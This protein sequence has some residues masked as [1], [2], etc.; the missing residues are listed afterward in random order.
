V[1][2]VG[3][4]GAGKSTFARTHFRPTE[5]VSSDAC[6]ALVADDENDQ[7]ATADAFRVLDLITA[8][9]L[10]RRH[11]T[12]VDA[13][14]VQAVWRQPL[15]ALAR[16]HRLPAVAIVFDLPVEVYLERTRVRTD[17]NAGAAVAR[18]HHADLRRFPPST[19]EGFEQVWTLRSVEEVAQVEVARRLAP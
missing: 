12:V 17:R 5:V 8:L 2:L 4:T 14:N 11:L 9:R 13:T 16:E 10:A 3:P 7:S 6:R 1:L 19:G 15:L 18:R